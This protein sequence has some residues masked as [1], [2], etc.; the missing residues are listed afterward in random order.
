VLLRRTGLGLVAPRE[1]TDPAVARRIAGAMA[2]ELGWN[3]RRTADEAS[4]WL[5]EARAEDLVPGAAALASHA[6]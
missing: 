3:E 6:A 1:V 5:R 4:A 2:V